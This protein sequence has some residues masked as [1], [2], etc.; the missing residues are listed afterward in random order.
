MGN[1]KMI[2]NKKLNIQNKEISSTSPTFVI[3]E[4]GVN[5]GGDMS[6]AKKL[7]NLSSEAGADA[8]KFQ[9][10]RA[11]HLILDSV[12]KA[13]YQQKTTEATESQMEML[14]KLGACQLSD[15]CVF[16]YRS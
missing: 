8:V 3:A 5:H 7:I 14:K 11:E 9:T 6:L 13:P 16:T 15:A 2:F 4:A 10:F 12:K 1:C